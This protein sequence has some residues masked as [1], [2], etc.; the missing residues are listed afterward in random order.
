MGNNG[1]ST[2]SK[3]P[4]GYWSIILDMLNTWFIDKKLHFLFCNLQYYELFNVAYYTNLLWPI[5]NVTTYGI[6][7]YLP[8]ICILYWAHIQMYF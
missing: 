3:V 4:I 1:L 7:F 2:F 5:D 6:C 8:N